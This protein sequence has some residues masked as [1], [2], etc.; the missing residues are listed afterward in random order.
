M[1][2]LRIC[3]ILRCKSSPADTVPFQFSCNKHVIR[4]EK[5]KKRIGYRKRL[6]V[7][8]KDVFH[9]SLNPLERTAPFFPRILHVKQV[10]AFLAFG[11]KNPRGNDFTLR[12]SLLLFFALK[13]A[14]HIRGYVSKA[15]FR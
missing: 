9:C 1:G 3:L 7:A 10:V 5:K 14:K 4:H 15:N 11:W 13:R 2:M 12:K 6:F 8:F